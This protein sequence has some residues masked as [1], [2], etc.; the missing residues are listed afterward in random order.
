VHQTL[1]YP[2]QRV[3]LDRYVI[4]EP[5]RS[6]KVHSWTAHLA[7]EEAHEEFA[8]A[9]FTVVEVLG[10]VAGGPYDAGS[11]EFAVVAAPT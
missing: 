7:V 5:D 8:S 6:R 9:G 3:A 2:D 10:D 11:P 1:L 4:V